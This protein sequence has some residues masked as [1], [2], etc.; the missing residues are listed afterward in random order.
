MAGCGFP[1]AKRRECLKTEETMSCNHIEVT[2][3][4]EYREGT[5]RFHKLQVTRD[6]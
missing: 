4:E 1:K 3:E 5:T 2:G 6:M